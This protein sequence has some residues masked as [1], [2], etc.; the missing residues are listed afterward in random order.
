MK[1]TKTVKA[2]IRV[3]E[4]LLEIGEYQKSPHRKIESKIR[5]QK[6]L[7][8]ID[9]KIFNSNKNIKH[10]DIGCGDGFV[11]ECSPSTWNSH[12]VDAAPL[13]LEACKKNHQHVLTYQ[14]TADSLPFDDESID[15]VTCYSFL[16]HL[17]NR[18]SFYKEAKRVLK[19]DGVCYFG[20]SPNRIFAD[21]LK[22]TS[23]DFNYEK[24]SQNKLQ[25]EFKKI[26]SNGDHYA[27][28]FDLDPEDLIIAEP[29]KSESGGMNP[30]DEIRELSTAG[31]KKIKIT[32]NW[33]MAQ[34]E[35]DEE[36]IRTIEQMLPISASCFKYFDIFAIKE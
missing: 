18:S 11:F 27:D 34:N 5:L 17:E 15:I 9:A 32:Y 14:S 21:A 4:K 19:K 30:S 33:I 3:H 7:K 25:H 29:G 1:P 13:M 10:A 12:G 2:N 31:F 36:T 24:F 23:D 6:I 8:D 35:L 28:E 16:D 20:L 22:A 26:F